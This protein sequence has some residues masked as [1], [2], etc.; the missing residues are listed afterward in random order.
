[1]QQENNFIVVNE[2][3][4]YNYSGP[5]TRARISFHEV[6]G[7]IYLICQKDSSQESISEFLRKSL[8]INE[9][10]YT[11]TKAEKTSTSSSQKKW[12]K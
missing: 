12:K 1:M 4:Y 5:L 11:I 6:K 9:E 10:N 8:F 3:Q 2:E 7:P